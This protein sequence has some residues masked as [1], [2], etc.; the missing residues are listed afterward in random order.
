MVYHLF[1]RAMPCRCRGGRAAFV[2]PLVL[3]SI[4]AIGTPASTARA[5]LEERTAPG[6]RYFNTFT[7]FY[8][9]DY[10]EALAALLNE[11]RGSIKTPQSRWIDS[12][13][14]ETMIGECYYEMGR[15]KEALE[16]YT[17]ALNLFKA[18]SDWMLR[19]QFPPALRPLPTA[20]AIPWGASSRRARLASYPGTMLIGLGRI[21]NNEQIRHG[22][23]IQQATLYPIDPQEIVRCTTLAIRRRASLLGP[24]S[25]Y[26]PLMADVL[27]VLSRH[28]G[29]PNHWSEAWLNTELGLVLVAAGREA[30]GISTLRQSLLA[31][32]EFDHQMSSVALFELGRLALVQGD[33]STAAKHFEEATYAAFHYPDAGVLE[34]AFRYGAMTHLM[35]NRPGVYP[36]LEAA[37]A[38]AKVKNLRQLQASLLLMRAENYAVLGQAR[39]AAALLEE[40][41]LAIGRREMGAGRIGARLSFLSALVLFQQKKMADGN[42]ALGAAMKYMQQGSLGLFQIA[43]VDDLLV[44]GTLKD[45]GPRLAMELYQEVLRD[46]SPADWAAD[47]MESLAVLET[48]HPGPY[49]RW[50][51]VALERKE[52]EAALEIADRSRRHRF[53]SS[54]PFGGRLLSLRWI[55]EGPPEMLGQQAQLLRQDLL[56]RWPAYSRLSQQARAVHAALAALPLVAQDAET[57]KQQTQALSQLAAL[58][59]QQETALEEMALRREPAGLV[60]PPLRTT[61]DI[62]KSLPPGHALLAF[63][64]T[65]GRLYGF[66]LNNQQYTYWQ[67]GSPATLNRQMI[68]LLRELGQYQPNHE[69]ALKDLSESWKQPAGQLLD[70][71]LKGSRADFSQKFDELVIVP[72]GVL[73]YLPFEALQVTAE[74]QSRPLISKV[75]VR[76]APTASLATSPAGGH[77]AAGNTVVAVGRLYPREDATAAQ[78]AC[79]RIARVL[80]GT[81][82]LR[83]PLPAASA[84][85]ASL[86]NRLIV[87]DDINLAGL[88]RYDEWSPLP[89]ERGKPGNTLADW[90]ALPWGGPEEI[91]LPGYHTAAEDSLKGLNRA[92]PG[93]EIFMSVCA[94][95]STGA[96][97]LLVSRWRTGGQTSLDLVREFAQELP[98]TSPADAWQRAV[99]VV[100]GAPLNLEA[101]P[102]IKRG[103]TEESPKANHPFFWAGYLLVDS[104]IASAGPDATPHEPAEK[105]HPPGQAEPKANQPALP[106]QPA[107][108]PQQPQPPDQPPRAPPPGDEPTAPQ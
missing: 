67:L 40:A 71:V 29:P 53:F 33:Y 1:A 103:A 45:R 36:P 102:R 55:L 14:Y 6:F 50:F 15:F 24:V 100:A 80:P 93:S 73:W 20:K 107:A 8:D 58:S 65:R 88:G 12:I 32:G 28:P 61:Q 104:G 5:A 49:E 90:L 30:Q 10:K 18:Y 56:V 48:P 101:E 31:A 4:V 62:Q 16:H 77:N 9:G 21:D 25:Q 38:W 23:V 39:E 96:R 42:R 69:L 83:P 84:V 46:P 54:L 63:F 106:D 97:T 87:L 52:H 2:V 72:D 37:A 105:V 86:F 43:L 34:E 95:L 44:S 59:A 81:V 98:H 82:A 85:Y 27:A 26:D 51:E 47:P 60:F 3:L 92:A 91:I 22:G 99:F 76:Y 108:K 35:A 13:C 17:A 79:E 74:G 75:R 94:L 68:A 41:R 19:V 89:S 7:A 66:L 70:L 11:A 57:L 78:A 64:A